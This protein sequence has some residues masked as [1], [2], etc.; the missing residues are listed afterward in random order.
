LTRLGVTPSQ[1]VG[2]FFAIA[3]PWPAGPFAAGEDEPGAFTIS[4]TVTDG[5]G[6]PIPDAVVETWQ[7]DAQGRFGRRAGFR[8]FA[9]VPTGDD[10]TF[11]LRTV[12]PAPL[13]GVGGSE[14]STQAPHIDV[15]LFARGLLHRT[16]TRIYFA[17]E[18]AANAADPILSSVPLQRRGTLLAH[19]TADGYR[20]DIHLQ[21]A[22][23]TVFF[24]V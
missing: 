19:P 11:A 23:E 16:V 14:S 3:L 2:P 21:G 4:G 6:A 15:S 1:T 10:G 7:A 9:R 20:F 18:E 5:E 13:P 12:K 17:D 24:D 22:D 8:G